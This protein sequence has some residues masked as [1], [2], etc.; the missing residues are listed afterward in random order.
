M[1]ASS[2]SLASRSL[3]ASALLASALLASELPG[4]AEPTLVEA[5]S[6]DPAPGGGR[7]P[8]GCPPGSPEGG[9]DAPG[10]SPD[11]PGCPPS[12]ERPCASFAFTAATTAARCS[13]LRSERAS[14]MACTSATRSA[15]AACS[16]DDTSDASDASSI[17][18][19]RS[20]GPSAS[21]SAARASREACRAASS[22]S[23]MFCVAAASDER[24]SIS[25]S[26]AWSSQRAISG[27]C[28]PGPRPAAP[29]R[30]PAWS[31]L[32]S[33][34]LT[35]V[36]S[37][38]ARP[39]TSNRQTADRTLNLRAMAIGGLLPGLSL[40]CSQA[41][42]RTRYSH[43]CAPPQPRATCPDEVTTTSA[44]G[45]TARAPGH[46]TERTRAPSPDTCAPAPMTD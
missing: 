27:P 42:P 45:P 21:S 1:P 26:E 3:L 9:P 34:A 38:T 35:D 39:L 12:P 43:P 32:A 29:P 7:P 28:L 40:A 19:L 46:T 4:V 18:P 10:C 6:G 37:A 30:S 15:C 13:S 22:V 20:C 14:S 2:G 11:A 31:A 33:P 23:R 16:A 36:S 25:S 44:S 17:C 24:F 5:A 8:G 41:P